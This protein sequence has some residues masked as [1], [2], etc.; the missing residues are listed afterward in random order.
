MGNKRVKIISHRGNLSGPASDRENSPSYIIE[1]LQHF[2]V[3]VDVWRVNNSWM[4]GH[5][6]PRYEVEEDFFTPNM[7]LHLKNYEAVENI[8]FVKKKLQ[9]FWHRDD[10]MTLT[11]KQ[12]IWCYPG[13]YIKDSCVVE[14]GKPFHIEQKISGVCTDY[15]RDWKK[16]YMEKKQ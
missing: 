8:A 2:D 14:C 16:Y 6:S 10:E 9:W 5:D 1:A 11:N 7:W 4:L 3:E 13:V 15:P 12:N